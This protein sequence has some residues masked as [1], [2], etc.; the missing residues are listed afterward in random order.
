MVTG[1][2]IGVLISIVCF[3]LY[4]KFMHKPEA[5]ELSEEEERKSKE[6]NEHFENM[7]NYNVTQ[8]YGGGKRG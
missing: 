4:D 1:I 3:L 5:I 6:K 8:A 2:I 7:L